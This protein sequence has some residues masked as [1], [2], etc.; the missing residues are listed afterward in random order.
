MAQLINRCVRM[1]FCGHI[2][3]AISWMMHLIQKSCEDKHEGLN[4]PIFQIA[5]KQ[6]LRCNVPLALSMPLLSL[7][8]A[9][10]CIK[11]PLALRGLKVQ[12]NHASAMKDS[13]LVPCRQF[14]G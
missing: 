7:S 10:W 6:Q 4:N 14:A 3:L 12:H 8:I 11:P 9:T 13:M 2:F 1:Y 5:I